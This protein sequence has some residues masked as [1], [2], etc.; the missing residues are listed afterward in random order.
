[1]KRIDLVRHLERHG[2]E[3]AREGKQHTC[4][5]IARQKDLLPC[6]D[7]VKSLRARLEVFVARL[8]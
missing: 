8:E 4:T 2:C 1:M 6:P 7:T 5:L 3:F